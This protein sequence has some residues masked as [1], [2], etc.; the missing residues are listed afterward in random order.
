MSRF[1]I[2]RP[3]FAWVIALVIL[4]AGFLALRT[5][6]IEQYPSVAPPALTITA[7]YPGADPETLEQNVTQIIEQQINGVE[8]FLYMSS[9]SGSTGRASVNVTFEAGTDIDLAQTDVQNR[10]GAIEAR[11]NGVLG[12]G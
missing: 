4:L 10:L 2:D 5:L 1:F 3:I 7:V 11:P 9:D 8:G 12:E 6:P